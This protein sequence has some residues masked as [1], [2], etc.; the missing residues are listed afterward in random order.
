MSNFTGGGTA[1][2][3]GSAL[4]GSVLEMLS[5]RPGGIAGLAATFQ[6]RGL[7]DVV[8]SWIGTGANLPVSGDQVQQVLGPDQIQ[9][10]AQ[11]MGLSPEAAGSQ[12][13]EVLPG[14]VDKLTPNGEVST[15]GDLMS[16][17]MGLLRGLMSGGKSDI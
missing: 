6:Q 5:N 17:G 14:I 4:I 10:F 16:T 2:G 7:G 12:L 11:K 1:G 13:A 8:S 9:A 3:A 15:G